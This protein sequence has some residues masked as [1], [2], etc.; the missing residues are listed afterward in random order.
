MH[1]THIKGKPVV[2]ARLIRTL[3][4]KIYKAMSS[5]LRNIS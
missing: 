5:V 2:A 4:N 1:S 3:K